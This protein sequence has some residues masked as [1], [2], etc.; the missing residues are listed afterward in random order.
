DPI[1]LHRLLAQLKNEGVDHLALEASSHG[2]DQYRIDGVAI[3][4]AAFTNITRDHLDY[5]QNF[6]RYLESKLRLF[7]LVGDRGVAVVNADAPHSDAFI[8]AA[9]RQDLQL[10]TVGKS[11]ESLKVVSIEPEDRGQRLRVL[12]DGHVHD[13]LLPLAGAFQASNALVA[14]AL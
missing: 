11:G 2:L 4:A 14:A 3:A 6:E 7:E 13:V 5:H 9:H 10:L 12:Y 1:E 8:A